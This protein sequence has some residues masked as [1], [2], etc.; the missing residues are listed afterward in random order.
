M[1]LAVLALDTHPAYRVLIAANRDEFHAR[2]TRPAHWWKEGWL[3]GRDDE[4][5]GTWLGIT[6]T[7]RW[8]LLTNVREPGR[9]DERAPSRG[10]LVP[11]MLASDT[12]VDLVLAR[13]VADGARYNGFNLLA[14]EGA[15]AWW[16]SNR[17]EGVRT[18]RRGVHGLSNAALD[19]PWPKVTATRQAVHDWCHAASAQPE[20]LLA[21]LG[22]RNLVDDDRLPRTGVALEWER[23]LSAPFIVSA[24]YGTRCSTVLAVGRD[25]A[26]SFVE[27]SYAPDGSTTGEVRECFRLAMAEAALRV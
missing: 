6:R 17:V 14:G 13:I 8:A 2:A 7:G 24:D 27:R 12:A 20:S 1:C 25:G 11:Q 21:A 23:R 19:T 26:V 9:R 10:A 18:L 4:A 3:A 16:A 5:G 22:D 15:E